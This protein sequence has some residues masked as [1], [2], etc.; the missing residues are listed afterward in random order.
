M[1]VEAGNGLGAVTIYWHDGCGIASRCSL[2]VDLI[3]ACSEPRYL[4]PSRGTERTAGG[5]GMLETKFDHISSI[6]LF[7]HS[8]QVV[9]KQ[10]R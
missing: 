2:S 8:H 7:L 6:H 10:K 5:L 9:S 1:S 3:P 4:E